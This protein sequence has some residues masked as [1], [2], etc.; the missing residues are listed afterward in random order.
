MPV[1]EL[2]ETDEISDGD[3]V[4]IDFSTGKV[5]DI[6][7]GK[8]Y[9]FAPLPQRLLDMLLDIRIGLVAQLEQE[10]NRRGEE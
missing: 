4:E 10:K 2:P 3:S 6:D 5:E 7:S 1:L 9:S 8:T